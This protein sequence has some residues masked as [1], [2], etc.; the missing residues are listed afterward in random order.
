MHIAFKPSLKLKNLSWTIVPW[1]LSV[2]LIFTRQ[3]VADG[4][5]LQKDSF[6][7]KKNSCC[8]GGGKTVIVMYTCKDNLTPFLY[9]EKKKKKK[10]DLCLKDC[11]WRRQLSD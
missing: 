11:L 8:K 1:G 10:K 3:N 2:Y 5:K 9:R 6:N 7:L 4:S